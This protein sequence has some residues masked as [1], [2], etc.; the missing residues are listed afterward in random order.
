M[1]KTDSQGDMMSIEGASDDGMKQA[2][3]NR[4]MEEIER[5]IEKCSKVSHRL[6]GAMIDTGFSDYEKRTIKNA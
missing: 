6:H 2:S 4:T 1:F 3:S 5:D